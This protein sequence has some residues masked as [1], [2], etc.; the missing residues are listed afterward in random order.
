MASMRDIKRRIK[1]VNSTR[2]ITKAMNL[3]AS[4]KLNKAK[5]RLEGT[6]PFAEETRKVIAEIGAAAGGLNNPLFAE[7]V[8]GNKALVIVLTGDKGLCG[9]YNSNVCKEAQ[10]L[11][12][13]KDAKLITV[14]TKGRDYF[15]RRSVPI[16]KSVV[17][18]SEHFEFGDAVA[19]GERALKMYKEKEVDAVYLVSTKYISSISSA[20]KSIRLLP[21]NPNEFEGEAKA[22]SLVLY[23]PSEEAVLEYIVPKYVNTVIYGGLVEASV[24]EL[25][26]RMTAMDAATDNAEE[27]L[28]S[29]NLLYNRVRQG[30][31]TNEITEIVNGSNALSQ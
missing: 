30:A 15:K 22:D 13:G 9:G 10:A 16:D 19:L 23:E 5:A 25:G 4:S 12:E 18:I 8:K 6:K 26:A 14:G 17:G 3:V 31:I 27:M 11:C 29:L 1:S 28:D 21:V 20:P 2:Q 7:E 24:C